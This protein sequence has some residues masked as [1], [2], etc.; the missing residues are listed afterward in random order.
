MRSLF[1]L[2]VLVWSQ[3]AYAQW[4]QT[5]LPT[6]STIDVVECPDPQTMYVSRSGDIYK[7][8]NAGVTWTNVAKNYTNYDPSKFSL[9]QTYG[10]KITF[11]DANIGFFYG[12]TSDLRNQVIFRT[13][14]GGANWTLVYNRNVGSIRKLAFTSATTGYAVGTLGTLLKTTDGGQTWT[15]LT[16]NTTQTLSD[17]AFPNASTA[18]VVGEKLILRTTDDGSSW[19]A[20]TLTVSVRSVSFMNATTGYAV[21]GT[22]TL[23]ETK[24][25]GATWAV[26]KT[27]LSVFASSTTF[28]KI[29]FVNGAFGILSTANGLYK[30]QDGKFWSP[31]RG[32]SNVRIDDFG[33]YNENIGLLS[34]YSNSVSYKMYSTTAGGEAMPQ[35][36]AL[37]FGIEKPNPEQCRGVYPVR[38][39]VVNMG[40]KPLTSLT[41]N[42]SVDGVSQPAFSWTGSLRPGDTTALVQVG[43]Y[44]FNRTAR[45]F[46]VQ[47]KAASPNGSS[48]DYTANDVANAVFRFNIFTGSYTLGTDASDDFTLAA[49]ITTLHQNGVCGHVV[50]NVKDGTYTASILEFGA[51]RGVDVDHT[52]TVQSLSNDPAK[53]ILNV[54]SGIR[55]KT[56]YMA[57]RGITVRSP[58]TTIYCENTYN[59]LLVENNVLETGRLGNETAVLQIVPCNGTLVVRN[60]VIRGGVNGI[61]YK[62]FNSWPAEYT[63]AQVTLEGNTVLD[64]QN[65]CIQ[66]EGSKAK[67]S[68]LANK[69][70]G[71]VPVPGNTAYYMGVYAIYSTDV[72]IANNYFQMGSERI[73]PRGVVVNMGKAT[74]VH[75]TFDMT[76]AS[77]GAVGVAMTGTTGSSVLNNIFS[78]R[79]RGSSTSLYFSENKDF[80]S[81]Y[82][83]LYTTNYVGVIDEDR[84]DIFAR[85]ARDLKE[86]RALSGYDIHSI[87]VDPQL[88]PGSPYIVPATSNYALQGAG[89]PVAVVSTDIGGEPRST[90]APD[91]GADEFATAATDLGIQQLSS[92]QQVCGQA[93]PVLVN[94]KNYGTT[95]VGRYSVRWSI[96]GVTQPV[97]NQ[98]TTL[99][100]GASRAVSVGS[101]SLAPGMHRIAVWLTDVTGDVVPRNDTISANLRAGGMAGTYTVGG[102]AA[103]FATPA[104]ALTALETN[105][106]C[107]P[108]ILNIRAGVYQQALTVKKYVGVSAVNTVTIQSENQNN[109]SVTLQ[110]A[111]PLVLDNASWIIVKN[112]QFRQ[113][114]SRYGIVTLKNGTSHNTLQSS[115]LE[116]LIVDRTGYH[117][118]NTI[119][120]NQFTFTEVIEN[121]VAISMAGPTAVN[122]TGTGAYR[123]NTIRNNTFTGG[124][125]A[126]RIS[127]QSGLVMSGNTVINSDWGFFLEYL[128]DDYRVEGNTM[129]VSSIGVWLR[130]AYN[131][132]GVKGLVVNNMITANLGSALYVNE[133]DNMAIYH[134]TLVT[135]TRGDASS[136]NSAL[137][138]NSSMSNGQYKNIEVKN[139]IVVSPDICV[140]YSPTAGM[141]SDYNIFWTTSRRP[142]CTN[143][144]GTIGDPT[145]TKKYE[146]LAQ[147]GNA[148]GQDQHSQFFQ[149]R[150][151]SA[152]NR[153]IA[154][155]ARIAKKGTA[156]GILKDIDGDNRHAGTPDP[157]ADEF[158][159]VVYALDAGIAAVKRP[160]SCGAQH[161]V[162]VT[163]KNFGTTTLTKSTI[164]W[165]INGQQQTPYAWTGSLALNAETAVTV[166]EFNFY[167]SDTFNIVAWPE[168]PNGAADLEHVNDTSRVTQ[169]YQKLNG[170]YTIGND[171][172]SNYPW[173][174][175]PRPDFPNLVSAAAYLKN[176]GICGPVTFHVV[177]G[178][179]SGKVV[180]GAIEGASETNRITFQPWDADSTSVVVTG[181]WAEDGDYMI[182]L[183]G[184]RYVSLLGLT[185]D[186]VSSVPAIALS[187]GASYNEIVGMRLR[188]LDEYSK[189]IYFVD[190]TCT[191]NTL[192]GNF[193]GGGSYGIVSNATLGNTTIRRNH[194]Q[195]AGTGIALGARNEGT[196]IDANRIEHATE[197]YNTD[198]MDIRYALDFTVSNNIITGGFYGGIDISNSGSR[199]KGG[200]V[201][202]NMV[203]G[204]EAMY[205]GITS[206]T[207][208]RIQ[209]LYNSVRLISESPYAIA[210]LYVTRDSAVTVMNNNLVH[211]G[212]GYPI[213]LEDYQDN[214]RSDYNNLWSATNKFKWDEA[215]V[216]SLEEY[217]G[218]SSG[219]DVH[220][221]SVDPIFV[222]A[223]DLH[224]L[225]PA[226]NGVGTP[227]ADVAWDI[228]GEARDASH[229]DVG[230]D[231]ID[232][233]P[234]D[235]GIAAVT[236]NTPCLGDNELYAE[237]KNFGTSLL[238]TATIQWSVNDVEQTPLAWTGNLNT[239]ESVSVK[240]GTVSFPSLA[241][242]Q[243]R[244]WTSLPNNLED[245][246]ASND[247]AALNGVKPAAH[248]T[249][250]IGRYDADFYT[251]RQAVE[252]LRTYGVCGPT[253]FLIQPDIYNEQVLLEH[254]RGTSIDNPIVFRS[255]T[256]DPAS[257]TVQY[258]ATNVLD[259]Y[260]WRV[261]DADFVTIRD[262]T[263]VA[264]G[265]NYGNVFSIYGVVRNLRILNNKIR[266]TEKQ[267]G[268]NDASRTAVDGWPGYLYGS[269]ISNNEITG[270]GEGLV[271]ISQYAE[272][273]EDNVAP[274]TV[275]NN[276]F[277]NQSSC[278]ITGRSQ[279]NNWRIVGNT[280]RSTKPQLT[281]A[282][283]MRIDDGRNLVIERNSIDIYGQG[284]IIL[285]DW[286]MAM[287]YGVVANNT[288]NLRDGGQPQYSTGIAIG[289]ATG[290]KL[291]YNTV[292]IAQKQAGTAALRLNYGLY[293]HTIAVDVKNNILVNEGAG[294]ALE[295]SNMPLDEFESDH[296]VLYTAGENVVRHAWSQI[297]LYKTVAAWSAASQ[298]DV[299]SVS[300]DPNFVSEGD[301]HPQAQ[302]ILGVGTPVSVVLDK[303]GKARHAQYPVP[304]AY[305]FGEP[306]LA[307]VRL[308]IV[309]DDRCNATQTVRVKIT[310]KSRA[311]LT[312]LTLNHTW[313]G[314][315]QAVITWT[316]TIAYQA[317]VIYSL[318][319]QT[320]P[321]G[322]QQTIN[323]VASLPN[324]RPDVNV[325]D[326]TVS[327]GFS[328]YPAIGGVSYLTACAVD[329]P[330]ELTVSEH[331]YSSY[332]WNTGSYAQTIA[333]DTSGIYKV[334]VTD[335]NNCTSTKEYSV[336]IVEVSKPT[337]VLVDKTLQASV[338]SSYQ[339]LLNGN[340]IA[341]ATGQD[342]APTEQGIYQVE[343]AAGGCTSLSDE[344][345]LVITGIEPVF[346]GITVEPVP[347]RRY[348]NV[349]VG[350]DMKATLQVSLL[351]SIGVRLQPRSIVVVDQGI[352]LDL[353]GLAPGVYVLELVAGTRKAIRKV[354]IE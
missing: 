262:M 109:T 309:E 82:N 115:V 1:L 296:N 186:A 229:P 99:A 96:D 219:T 235:A 282:Y 354:I 57:L 326:N 171:D 221:I 61:G 242:Y 41:L 340:P 46:A 351:S 215:I 331:T 200:N 5:T 152:T 104:D 208:K 224:A 295:V 165:S 284:G 170:G 213:H 202:N 78:N 127:Y 3:T 303:D 338:A 74:I 24:D 154:D 77:S 28:T 185:V 179:Y 16:S 347:T 113:S 14:D 103:D 120:S 71:T 150:F 294:V 270:G 97:S 161:P 149:P 263:I 344:V 218:F 280:I 40:V 106:V 174:D 231:E 253:T 196:V 267:G 54:E 94:V 292:R 286:D 166:G 209:Y 31:Q 73:G 145:Y 181:S 300:E 118:Y 102:T 157:G 297:T 6:A 243:V 342:Y 144:A 293:S 25:A 62:S 195:E 15:L 85:N 211:A 49:G 332:S 183:D 175:F 323:V 230:V 256:G 29:R 210:T 107:G 271:L 319:Q 133:V 81:D 129:R 153:H 19:T 220:S 306:V 217:L 23:Y 176:V 251:I 198:A 122:G 223:T 324:N 305:E 337:V 159:R 274:D 291:Y 4:I 135:V 121:S 260:V 143:N 281:L 266:M 276:I 329:A 311:P 117:E 89:K 349:N 114:A 312:R 21:A 168:L 59:S 248:G 43:T 111:M 308:D 155:D 128:L 227:I 330:V 321:V 112:L 58:Y 240:L 328:I 257:V 38:A 172:E 110:D 140:V 187:K 352:R 325:S 146:N 87:A 265:E 261:A 226:I 299:Y 205:F 72:L 214:W 65:Y 238:G 228:D 310:N 37:V 126:A 35:N 22:N 178:T 18:V 101:A 13:A 177:P 50:F 10:T 298:K 182:L 254:I 278:A 139:N 322:T 317:S 236:L 246:K 151:V 201:Y 63:N 98:T 285:E 2:F 222:S 345:K 138:V 75:N 258:T 137:H 249:Y 80:T 42:W 147:W 197:T 233:R 162:Q 335:A 44:D 190:G 67:V 163:L 84:V 51:I 100:P 327:T 131:P 313:A 26:A 244:V 93:A 76:D 269:S 203:A 124:N 105:G 132:N 241:S 272:R 55:L 91:I 125:Y 204:S 314:V 247:A 301:L 348:L 192:E 193:I 160:E 30:T 191:G 237:I 86:W 27:N 20:T 69:L 156:V 212:N 279:L 207:N 304:G 343:V 9:F 8:T 315:N 36:E 64:Q 33:F 194:I 225:N 48:D 318:P 95:A 239:G 45:D 336:T 250:T 167:P 255:Q 320:V 136:W 302:S 83:D 39:R 307:D 141:V 11:L 316:G 189:G 52:V 134:N 7:S 123:G 56:A 216:Q 173:A 158:A 252:M 108:V 288:V 34:S 232:V 12:N 169:V 53:V 60:N 268:P 341:G 70:L 339:W 130:Y 346:G 148:L 283:G 264:V 259:N 206:N 333:A 184:A 90:T 142:F 180:I 350:P 66:V 275:M 245:P 68:I 289:N 164:Q 79:S 88:L 116:Q 353:D 277:T 234:A 32:L 92:E 17:I 199:L 334:A 47:V 287:R 119:E 290:Y 273:Y 188:G